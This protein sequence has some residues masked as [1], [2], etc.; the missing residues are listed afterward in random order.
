MIIGY[1]ILKREVSSKT[2]NL[3][4]EIENRKQVEDALREREANYRL[5]VESQKDL[6]VKIDPY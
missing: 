3:E 5:M 6:I 2:R 1:L 4:I